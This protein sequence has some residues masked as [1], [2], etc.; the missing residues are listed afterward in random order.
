[1]MLKKQIWKK[2]KNV[3]EKNEKK[4]KNLGKKKFG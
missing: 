2:K 1:M 3:P 4:K